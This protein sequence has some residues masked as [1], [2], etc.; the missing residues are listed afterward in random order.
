MVAAALVALT[1][2]T[3]GLASDLGQ[4]RDP[5]E[6]TGAPESAPPPASSTTTEVPASMPSTSAVST[7]SST[8]TSTT[9]AS[10]R[11][12]TIAD[13]FAAALAAVELTVLGA[14]VPA[15]ARDSVARLWLLLG[16]PPAAA[17]LQTAVTATVRDGVPLDAL[18]TLLLS[19]PE[20]AVGS[21]DAPAEAFVAGL[22]EGMLGR[23]A[24][25]GELTA[26][27]RGMRDGMSPGDVA[28]GFAES[29]EAVRRTGTIAHES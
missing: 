18:A 3:Q 10:T 28:V 6:S 17:E 2:C 7:S 21:P 24:R 15:S 9:P 19:S 12:P 23:P 1:A 27:V 16:R 8:S 22:Y 5:V 4:D 11:P 26:W 13:E 29:P 14:P 20:R 25:P